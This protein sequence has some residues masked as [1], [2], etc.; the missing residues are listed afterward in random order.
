MY[1]GN[2]L[3]IEWADLITAGHLFIEGQRACIESQIIL[4]LRT[5]DKCSPSFVNKCQIVYMGS[6]LVSRW[7][8][9]LFL[10]P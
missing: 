1:D 2:E 3:M 6:S 5:I 8:R 4:E 9:L 10:V 7:D